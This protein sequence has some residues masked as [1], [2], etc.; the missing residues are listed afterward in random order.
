MQGSNLA[1]TITGDNGTTTCR[2]F[3]GN[4]MLS[5]GGGNDNL[6]GGG[7]NDT[8]DGGAGNDWLRGDSGNDTLIGGADLD[9][10]DYMDHRLTRRVPRRRASRS[11]WRPARR[12]TTGAAPTRFAASRTSTARTW[13]TRSRATTTSITSHGQ[14]G[15][16]TLIGRRRQRQRKRQSGQRHPGRRCRQRLHARRQRQR[17]DQWRRRLRYC[18]LLGLR[19]RSGGSGDAGRHVNLVAGTATDNWGGSDTLSSIENV[20]GS[21]LGTRSPAMA[22]LTI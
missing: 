14:G 11:T 6:Y 5:G 1:D 16:D 2:G 7:G 15:N 18:R 9:T 3:A 20:T 10:V 4:D 13:P 19:L 22:T 17:Y 12:P 8:L 21:N